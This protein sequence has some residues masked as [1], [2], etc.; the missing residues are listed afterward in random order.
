LVLMLCHQ[1]QS[2]LPRLVA[3]LRSIGVA[4]SERQG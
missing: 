1:G 4:I 2:T 3:L